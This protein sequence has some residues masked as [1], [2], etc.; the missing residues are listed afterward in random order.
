MFKKERKF[1]AS[2]TVKIKLTVALILNIQG[3]ENY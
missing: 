3:L 1:K 2:L